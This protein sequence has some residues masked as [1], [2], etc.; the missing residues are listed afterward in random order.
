LALLSFVAALVALPAPALARSAEV[1]TLTNPPHS[2]AAGKSFSVKVSLKGSGVVRFVLSTDAK[3]S[4]AD[5]ELAGTVRGSSRARSARVTVPAATPGGSYRLL[6][7]VGSACH[8]SRGKV[9]I[10]AARQDKLLAFSDAHLIPPSAQ[11][12]SELGSIFRMPCVPGG[13]TPSLSRALSDARAFIRAHDSAG[14]SKLSASSS[15]HTAGKAKAVAAGAMA[16]GKPDAALAAY[17]DAYRRDSKDPELLID[18]A[19]VMTPLGMPRDALALL[20]GA[21]ALGAPASAPAGFNLQAVSLNNRG[22]AEMAMCKWAAAQPALHAALALAPA[23]REARVNLAAVSLAT[24]GTSTTTVKDFAGAVHRNPQ[25]PVSVDTTGR[26]VPIAQDVFDMSHPAPSAPD[27]PELKLDQARTPAEVAGFGATYPAQGYWVTLDNFMFSQRPIAPPMPTGLS[28]ATQH[29][30]LDILSQLGDLDPSTAALQNRVDKDQQDVE[31]VL[32]EYF[33][34]QCGEFCMKWAQSGD[35]AAA[36]ARSTQVHSHWLGLMHAYL[37]DLLT[38]IQAEYRHGTALAANLAN[39]TLRADLMATEKTWVFA[40][41]GGITQQAHYW[42]SFMFNANVVDRN[43]GVGYSAGGCVPNQTPAQAL[44]VTA[45][46]LPDPFSCKATFG[47]APAIAI[48][49]LV[50][51]LS[52]S[53]EEVDAEIAAPELLGPFISGGYNWVS[54]QV[55]VFGGVKAGGHFLDTPLGGELDAGVYITV[56][57]SGVQ[58]VGVRATASGGFDVGAVTPTVSSG[59]SYGVADMAS[60]GAI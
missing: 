56:D 21:D 57:R 12:K 59:M 39:P 7:C 15:T 46:K 47:D 23:M 49:L 3:H 17:L 16:A 50:V 8:A 6:A 4:L 20:D 13:A 31:A 14:M 25:V 53:C 41:Y 38:L 1:A 28:P 48:N 9:K 45:P 52:I 2:V 40:E 60:T 36:C 42:A 55:T 33:E 51:S 5:P 34:G 27:L 22:Y 29:R 43:T 37:A 24:Q 18:M 19:G 26:A 44:P 58:D 11:L 54:G 35:P 32:S 30:Y 10:L